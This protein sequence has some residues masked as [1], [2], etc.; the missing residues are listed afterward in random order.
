MAVSLN[1]DLMIY[2]FNSISDSEPPNSLVLWVKLCKAATKD[3][4]DAWRMYL[5]IEFEGVA[6]EEKEQVFIVDQSKDEMSECESDRD[7]TSCAGSE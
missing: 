6:N 7:S 4:N 1:H 5:P 3:I 2:H